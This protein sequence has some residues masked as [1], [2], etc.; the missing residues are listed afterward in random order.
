M[1]LGSP[2]L[3]LEVVSC[4]VDLESRRR[5]DELEFVVVDEDDEF[6]KVVLLFEKGILIIEYVVSRLSEYLV[7]LNPFFGSKAFC[8]I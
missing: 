2:K 7:I 1:V 6:L 3:V 8:L 4:L 5:L